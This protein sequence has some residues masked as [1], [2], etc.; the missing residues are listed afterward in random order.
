MVPVGTFTFYIKET[1]YPYINFYVGAG[2]IG[3]IDNVSVKE[4][5]QDWTFDSASD[6]T[7]ED[8]KAVYNDIN[9]NKVYQNIALT[10]N[11]KYRLQFTISDASTYARM[12]VGNI[13]GN[14]N[15]LGG[16]Y[17]QYT[18][19]TYTIDF[20]MPSNQTTLAF[21][22]DVGGSS[23]KLDNISVK[24]VTDDTN[25]PRINY[26]GFTYAESLGDNLLSDPVNLVTDFLTNSG[27]IIVDSNTYHMH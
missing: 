23:F 24:K 15:Y 10:Q 5:G 22:G 7:F 17:V 6:W 16:G 20:V 9:T 3:S 27:G 4:V 11:A 8:N 26:E 14:I 21:Y 12:W 1:G 25:L 2:F 18:D 19:G 13:G